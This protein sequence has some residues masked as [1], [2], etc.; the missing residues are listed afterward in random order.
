MIY[1][2]LRVESDKMFMDTFYDYTIGNRNWYWQ[3]VYLLS[4]LN[5]VLKHI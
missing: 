1:D 3:G 4:A 5:V 2:L